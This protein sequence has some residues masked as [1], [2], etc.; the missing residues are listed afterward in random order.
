MI[1]PIHSLVS[2]LT[3]VSLVNGGVIYRGSSHGSLDESG[4]LDKRQMTGGTAKTTA[5]VPKFAYGTASPNYPGVV[6]KGKN[7]PTNPKKPSLGTSVN[8]TSISRLVSINSVDDW[9]TFGPKDS[10]KKL[11]NVEEEVV[12]YC[13]KPRNGARVIPDGTVTGAHFV[14]TPLYVQVMAHGDFTKINFQSGDTG[15]ELDPHGATEKGNPHGGNVTSNVS[16]KDVFYEEWMNYVGYNIMCFRVCIAGSDIAPPKTE[17]Q[18][19]LDEMGCWSVMPGDYSDDV[20]DSCDADAAYPPGVYVSD[21]TTSSFEQFATG[22][23]TDDGD[24][25]TFTNGVSTQKTPSIAMSTPRSSNCKKVAT[26]GNG[27]TSLLSPSASGEARIAEV[28]NSTS[29]VAKQTSSSKSSSIQATA[30]SDSSD[31]DNQTSTESDDS[32]DSSSK[33][34]ASFLSPSWLQVPI[35]LVALTIATI[36]L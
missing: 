14:K 5:D 31:T 30:S 16:G 13:T 33:S 3:F 15:G 6:A 21:G 19:T 18:H 27:I 2:L 11:G 24:L 12:A 8:Q 9:C 35:L 32:S 29:G 4:S 7:G 22:V 36:T 20:F 10:S 23:W 17:C 26:I 1:I 34:S 28:S 25:K